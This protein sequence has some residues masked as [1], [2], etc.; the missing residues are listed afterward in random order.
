VNAGQ[1]EKII[2]KYRLAQPVYVTRPRMPIFADYVKKLETIWQTRWLTNN[3][4]FHAE[5]EGK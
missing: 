2:Q 5:F 4:Q 1:S 3:G